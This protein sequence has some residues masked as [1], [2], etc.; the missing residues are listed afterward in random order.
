ML[1]TLSFA[2]LEE[3][4]DETCQG[5]QVDGHS[6]SES[7]DFALVRTASNDHENVDEARS[8]GDETNDCGD[9]GQ[10]ETADEEHTNGPGQLLYKVLM[11]ALRSVEPDPVLVWQLLRI[12]TVAAVREATY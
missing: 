12:A 1:A 5:E 6:E 7:T 10:E 4:R 8:D 9:Q 2:H 3:G 11:H